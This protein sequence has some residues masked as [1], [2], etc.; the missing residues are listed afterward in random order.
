MEVCQC[1][2]AVWRRDDVNMKTVLMGKASS[3][4]LVCVI[5]VYL[6]LSENTRCSNNGT[7]DKDRCREIEDKPQNELGQ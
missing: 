7:K 2:T 1:I 6:T 5:K 4:F 3:V